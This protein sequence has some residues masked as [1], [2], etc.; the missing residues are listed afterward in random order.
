MSADAFDIP[1]PWF[2]N[3]TQIEPGSPSRIQHM[4]DYMQSGT[5]RGHLDYH[6]NYFIYRWSVGGRNFEARAYSDEINEVSVF[7]PIDELRKSHYADV[8]TWL[9]RRFASIQTF[10]RES[11]AGYVT[12][13]KR[14]ALTAAT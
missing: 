5:M 8:V 3:G 12:R 6:Y 11:S 14:R 10:E 2:G 1:A 9:K 13:W 4:C 7:L